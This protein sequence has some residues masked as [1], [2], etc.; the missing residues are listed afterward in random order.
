M[1]ASERAEVTA[2]LKVSPE[3]CLEATKEAAGETGLA[4]EAGPGKIN[5]AGSKA[6]VLD[7]MRKVV[8]EALEA[9]AKSV[10]VEVEAK[11]DADRFG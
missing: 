6:E 2:E 7:A 10:E 5:L 11:D 8:D 1:P 3:D 4:H 9:G